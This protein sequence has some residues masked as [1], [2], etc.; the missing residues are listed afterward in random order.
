MRIAQRSVAN[1]SNNTD[2]L[3]VGLRISHQLK[4]FPKHVLPG[5]KMLGK[6]LIDQQSSR[7][8]GCV[9]LAKP[10]SSKQRDAHRCQITRRHLAVVRIIEFTRPIAVAWDFERAVAVLA[11]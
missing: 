6:C 11:C 2:D 3:A 4:M 10:S 9:I 7:T 8:I 5:E 1:V